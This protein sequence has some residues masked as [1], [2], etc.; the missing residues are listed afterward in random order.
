MDGD[1]ADEVLGSIDLT[2][3]SYPPPIRAFTIDRKDSLWGECN[4]S[5]DDTWCICIRFFIH[6]IIAG[7]SIEYGGRHP[8]LDKE[9]QL[10]FLVHLGKGAFGAAGPSRFANDIEEVC[11]A[12]RDGTSWLQSVVLL[13][14]HDGLSSGVFKLTVDLFQPEAKVQ[15]F[16]LSRARR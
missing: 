12:W 14:C 6:A 3:I 16:S 11:G 13:E 4:P 1:A 15:Q 9:E 7:R 8:I 2:K 10:A 5:H